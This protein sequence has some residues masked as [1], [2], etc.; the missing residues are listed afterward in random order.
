MAK[1]L[2]G[3]DGIRGVAGTYPLDPPTVY[4]AGL[5]LGR[6]L[7]A[8]GGGAVLIGMDTRESGPEIAECLAAGLED[9]GIQS[10]FAGVL[11]TAG[12]SYLTKPAIS[13]P[14]S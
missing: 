5:A 13:P 12:V 14:E 1:R 8:T 7:S 6:R 11:P 2:F 9:A 3:T 4:A 10:R